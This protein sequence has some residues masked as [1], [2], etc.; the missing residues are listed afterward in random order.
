MGRGEEA[1]YLLHFTYFICVCDYEMAKEVFTVIINAKRNA[2]FW[3]SEWKVCVVIK[4]NYTLL[5]T[6]LQSVS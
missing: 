2:T 5:A 3:D 6:D 4:K 1:S